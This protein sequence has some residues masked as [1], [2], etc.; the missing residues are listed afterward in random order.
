MGVLLY[1]Y[2]VTSTGKLS[3]IRYRLYLFS[4]RIKEIYFTFMFVLG[5]DHSTFRGGDFIIVL[6]RRQVL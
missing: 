6:C 1:I 4:Y 5:N 2:Y 3:M